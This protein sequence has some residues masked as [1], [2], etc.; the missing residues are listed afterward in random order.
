[1]SHYVK[2]LFFASL[3]FACNGPENF[4]DG[5]IKVTK[6]STLNA[7]TIANITKSQ[8][9]LTLENTYELTPYKDGSFI[10][11]ET[12]VFFVSD[13]GK[14][15][16]F[17][18][19]KVNAPRS[20][21][22][23]SLC[24]IGDKLFAITLENGNLMFK[25]CTE[26]STSGTSQHGLANL[27]LQFTGKTVSFNTGV[28]KQL[29]THFISKSKNRIAR[30]L[31]R[32]LKE[33][34]PVSELQWRD[35]TF[36]L[37]PKVLAC[38]NV[39]IE[40]KEYVFLLIPCTV[41]VK[42][43]AGQNKVCYINLAIVFDGETCYPCIDA[44][45]D[46]SYLYSALD[47]FACASMKAF[48]NKISFEGYLR[49]DENK[50]LPTL[51]L[52]EVTLNH[53]GYFYYRL[54]STHTAENLKSFTFLKTQQGNPI[55]TALCV[56]PISNKVVFKRLRGKNWSI[57]TANL[58]GTNVF[59]TEATI[60]DTNARDYNMVFLQKNN[61]LL[62]PQLSIVDDSS[63]NGLITMNKLTISRN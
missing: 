29:D 62:Q 53:D 1:M 47:D 9:S 34:V 35:I 46:N 11:N 24:T 16:N 39:A 10:K 56:D 52:G 12:G 43:Q 25:E 51:G 42:N 49:K 20:V 58:A 30:I 55:L 37:H 26:S 33:V 54:I 3:I 45:C 6:V 13:V 44:P 36:A 41:S 38:S 28:K 31:S 61:I 15:Q 32:Q 48:A 60:P 8:E 40:E 5:E 27:N 59:S 14:G 7:E 19:K 50:L 57:Q 63:L 4:V 22:I 17:D 18:I 2:K 21:E 23:E